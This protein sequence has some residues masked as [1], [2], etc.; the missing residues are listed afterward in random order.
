MLYFKHNSIYICMYIDCNTLYT[1]LKTYMEFCF[2]LNFCIY[3]NIIY[4]HNKPIGNICIQNYHHKLHEPSFFFFCII[5]VFYYTHSFGL[6]FTSQR[7][8]V[9]AILLCVTFNLI[10]PRRVSIKFHI[11][12][13]RKKMRK[14]CII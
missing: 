11:I 5:I 4:I 12:N 10:F 3:V 1:I 7:T 8:V 14:K 2:V 13:F 6:T 9:F